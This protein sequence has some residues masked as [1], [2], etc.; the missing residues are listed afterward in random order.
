[1][2]ST[3]SAMGVL[4]SGNLYGVWAMADIKSGFAAERRR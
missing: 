3:L 2:E 4:E 1:M